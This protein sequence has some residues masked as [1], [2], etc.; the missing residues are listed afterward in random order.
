MQFYV[1]ICATAKTETALNQGLR[2]EKVY[3]KLIHKSNLQA[4]RLAWN[5]MHLNGV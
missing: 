3:I 1:K 4:S 5:M 2:Y